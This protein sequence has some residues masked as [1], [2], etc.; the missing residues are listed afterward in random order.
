MNKGPKISL[1]NKILVGERGN[2]VTRQILIILIWRSLAVATNVQK[3]LMDL[4][5]A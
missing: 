1:P 3:D 2:P 5:P 4:N